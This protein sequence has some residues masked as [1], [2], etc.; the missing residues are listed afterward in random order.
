MSEPPETA[1]HFGPFVL[2]PADKSLR[3]DGRPIAL[4][5]K[6]FDT[7]L[8]LVKHGGRLMTKDDL[9]KQ[10][11]P[12]A[13]VEEANLAQ[14][15]SVLRRLLG[16][17][18]GEP[19]FIETVPKRGYRF[20]ATV[21]RG[22]TGAAV[23]SVAPVE[24]VTATRSPR[25]SW[26]RIGTVA[27]ALV[28]VVTAGMYFGDRF[29]ASKPT[30]KSMLLVP[31][32][33]N[34]TGD[35][36]DEYLTEGLTEEL[37]TQL[38]RL[39]PT[40]LAVMAQ[41][42]EV[43]VNNAG[44]GVGGGGGAL[45]PG[46]ILEGS[47]R[48]DGNRLRVTARLTQGPERTLV[49]TDAYEHDL[50]EIL[51]MQMRVARAV[52]GEIQTRLSLPPTALPF[53]A[54]TENPD[55]YTSYL[56]AHYFWNKRTPENA[57]K[58]IGFYQHA[59][60]LDPKFAQ[61]YAEMSRCYL[62]TPMPVPGEAYLLAQAAA[63]KALELDESLG[64]AHFGLAT[65]AL[66]LFDWRTAE[67][68][69][70]RAEALEPTLQNVDFMVLSGRFEDAMAVTRRGLET[71]PVDLLARHGA[72]I[73]AFYARDYPQA[74]DHYQQA[75]ELDPHYVYSLVRLGQAYTQV[76]RYDDAIKVL[77]EAG[78]LGLSQLGYIYAVTGRKAEALEILKR[79]HAWSPTGLGLDRA[80][81]YTGLGD[82]DSAFRWLNVAYDELSYQL[83]YLKV[84][85]R[86]DPLRSDPRYADLVRRIGFPE[87]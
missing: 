16:D 76:G 61:A 86:L 30:G 44:L 84:D 55:A 11:W 33:A 59:V 47:L 12:D 63:R 29:R 58:A 45:A 40:R 50:S 14:N 22:T 46:Y 80:L 77:E 23:S 5:P 70:R 25:P 35:V 54:G 75:L 52:A 57:T 79:M 85:P 78:V 19:R 87:G 15:I 65:A 1:Y 28:V 39:E 27:I 37:I 26:Q 60:S 7:L 68:E 48:R 20:V 69:F 62:S 13:F 56:K 21:T 6:V 64:E 3:Q 8:A 36:G 17:Q 42:S 43:P 9:M 2:D 71:D 73:N 74:I 32:F 4:T 24:D 18:L 31:P 67:L 66:H 51:V 53:D 83:I 72:G 34:L 10:V 81:V 49:W 38:G 82:R 41:I